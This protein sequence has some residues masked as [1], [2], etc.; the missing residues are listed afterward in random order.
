MVKPLDSALQ[1]TGS[2]ARYVS[3][4]EILD[5]R[6]ERGTRHATRTM[7]IRPATAEDLG[8]IL[9]LNSEWE[10]FTSPLDEV[11]LATLHQQAAYHRVA[12]VDS[13]VAAFLLAL[14]PGAPYESSNYIWFAQRYRR[15]LYIDRIVVSHAEQRAGLGAALYDD[16]VVWARAQ[17][18]HR[19]TCE[20]DIEPLNAGSDAFHERRGFVEVGT[21]WVAGGTKLVSL[22]ESA[23]D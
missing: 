15:F 5:P 9:L 6:P 23:L 12:E 16:L 8:T 4:C 17:G 14:G 2:G 7:L 13:R 20:V 18:V 22:R 11:S 3:K 19:L 1:V 21:Q 10:H